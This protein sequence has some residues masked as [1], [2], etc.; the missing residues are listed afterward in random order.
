MGQSTKN[1]DKK[2]LKEATSSLTTVPS[3][4]PYFRTKITL[5]LTPA[6]HSKHKEN[7]ADRHK[8]RARNR[9]SQSVGSST[10]KLFKNEK[11]K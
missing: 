2:E 6:K 5:P 1:D 8:S 9:V 4:P 3:D 10:F 11:K 7:K